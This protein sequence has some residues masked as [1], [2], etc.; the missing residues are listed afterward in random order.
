[1]V[2]GMTFLF[3]SGSCSAA[4]TA[5]GE[6]C[7]KGKWLGRRPEVFQLDQRLDE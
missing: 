6:R 4:L 3:P 1:M 5:P 2:G 7:V